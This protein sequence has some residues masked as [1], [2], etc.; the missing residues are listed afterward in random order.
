M[1]VHDY[2]NND[3]GDHATQ[4][5]TGNVDGS[6]LND[7]G[8]TAY[9]KAHNFYAWNGETGY[10]FGASDCNTLQAQIYG[11][12]QAVGSPYIGS[13]WFLFSHNSCCDT[14]PNNFYSHEG[15]FDSAETNFYAATDGEAPCWPPNF[16]SGK[17]GLFC[18]RHPLS[19]HPAN[20]R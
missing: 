15:S 7:S 12:I 6:K 4:C 16:S 10:A 8:F 20:V 9:M 1:E 17:H 2:P 13:A 11:I 14:F 19:G 5:T 18:L 3:S